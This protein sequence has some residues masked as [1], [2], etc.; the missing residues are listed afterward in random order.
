MEK[1]KEIWDKWPFPL[2]EYYAKLG[3]IEKYV[4][5]TV[6]DKILSICLNTSDDINNLS[7]EEIKD[8]ITEIFNKNQDTSEDLSEAD[9][10]SMIENMDKMREFI[11]NIENKISTPNC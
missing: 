10:I 4:D 6:F 1:Y 3:I 9:Y 5:K 11:E 8:K 7:D 2:Q